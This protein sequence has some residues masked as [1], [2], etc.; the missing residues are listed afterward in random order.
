MYQ[1]YDKDIN[2][3][4]KDRL[5]DIY[6]IF[7]VLDKDKDGSISLKEIKDFLVTLKLDRESLKRSDSSNIASAPRQIASDSGVKQTDLEEALKTSDQMGVNIAEDEGGLLS[8]QGTN[9]KSSLGSRIL[10][11]MDTDMNGSIDFEEFARLADME[12]PKNHNIRA[13]F[14]RRNTRSDENRR[15]RTAEGIGARGSNYNA[16]FSNYDNMT[17]KRLGL[18]RKH[19]LSRSLNEQTAAVGPP[20]III[21]PSTPTKRVNFAKSSQLYSRSHNDDTFV[22]EEVLV[23]LK[24]SKS[25]DDLT[26]TQRMEEDKDEEDEDE[27][28]KEYLELLATVFSA[29]D[30]DGDGYIDKTE[31]QRVLTALGLKVTEKG[32]VDMI[33]KAD[34]D[35]NQRIDFEE[36]VRMNRERDRLSKEEK[37][38]NSSSLDLD[39][40]MMG[41]KGSSENEGTS[42][43]K[44]ARKFFDCRRF[45]PL[46]PN[47]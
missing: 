27:E 15:S 25:G 20:S 35:G 8:D 7:S 24:E 26:T 13:S 3:I 17:D 36:F 44:R 22:S 31:I 14:S 29:F 10:N 46:S 12:L 23:P 39:P 34:K 4:P 42:L 21:K 43:L 32:L 18:Q 30:A 19:R 1:V 38:K 16:S 28:E 40:N 37:D 11:M 41:G 5:K 33:A 9:K 2:D 47:Q 45:F 6:E